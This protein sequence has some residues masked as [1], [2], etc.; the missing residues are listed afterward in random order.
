MTCSENTAE[1]A[2]SATADTTRKAPKM[3]EDCAKV[4][5]AAL[6]RIAELEQELKTVRAFIKKNLTE[7][8]TELEPMLNQDD[9]DFDDTVRR[10]HLMGYTDALDEVLELLKKGN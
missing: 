5:D 8:W 1:L 3:H 6:A 7:S 4:T 2:L 9:E 10:I